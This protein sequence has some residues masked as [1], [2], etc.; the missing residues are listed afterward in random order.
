MQ[1]E[2]PFMGGHEPAPLLPL[3]VPPQRAS[4]RGVYLLGFLTGLAL[5]LMAGVVLYFFIAHIGPG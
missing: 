3:P 1:Q 4:S 2:P 5:S